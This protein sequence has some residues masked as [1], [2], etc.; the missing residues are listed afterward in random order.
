MNIYNL[1]YFVTLARIRQYTKA[2]EELC[3][4]QPSL[5]HAISQMEKELG[6]KLFEKNGHKITLTQF[7]DD[8]IDSIKRSAV[9]N[10]TIRLGIVRPLGISYVPRMAAAFIK[11]NPKL[12]I[13][14]TFHTD[15]TG[16]LLDD[17]QLGKY[18][19]L[20][21]SKPSEEY[22]FTAEPVM[23]QRLVLITSKGHPLAKKMKRSINLAETAGYSYVCFDKNSGIRSIFDEMLKKADITVKVAYETEEDQVI[24]G[25]VANG[26]GIAVVPY[27]DILEKM[28]VEIFEIESPEYERSFYM[29]NDNSTYMSPAVETFRN[30]VIEN[31][32][33]LTAL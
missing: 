27:M 20:F 22:H 33:V 15:V 8:G 16:R 3:I 26:F 23:K 2:A 11:K 9:G 6:V 13:D 10:G 30:F 7:G 19:L 12:D 4:T 24:A 28:S 5:S 14:F 18:D 32:S 31:T 29:V 21:C 1:R 17:M 25:L